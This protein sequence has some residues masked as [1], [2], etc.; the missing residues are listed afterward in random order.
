[1]GGQLQ[2]VLCKQGMRVVFTVRS[3]S[4]F[5]AWA[6]KM[7]AAGR[8]TMKAAWATEKARRA[9]CV[10]RWCCASDSRCLQKLASGEGG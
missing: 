3:R 8:E 4:K 10:H 2:L 1:M 7:G 5:L 6:Q 9:C